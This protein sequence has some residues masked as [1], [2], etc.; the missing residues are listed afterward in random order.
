VAGLP[1]KEGSRLELGRTVT[2]PDGVDP[3]GIAAE[4]KNGLLH[5]ELPKEEQRK[6]RAIEVR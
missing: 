3:A 6:P 1:G 4:L 5:L 2:I